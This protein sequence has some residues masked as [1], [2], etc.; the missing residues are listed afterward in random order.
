[1]G[2]VMWTGCAGPEW[3]WPFRPLT[4]ISCLELLPERRG[5]GER[6]EQISKVIRHDVALPIPRR[7]GSQVPIQRA[8]GACQGSIER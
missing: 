2:V 6:A 3:A 1:M 8:G 7:L 5:G 4:A